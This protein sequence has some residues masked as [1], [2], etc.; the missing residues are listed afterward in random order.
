VIL[1][2]E[3][4]HACQ[5][6][7]KS[8]WNR[9]AEENPYWYVSSY[10]SY[11]ADRNLEEFWATRHTIWADMHLPSYVALR[12]GISPI[13]LEATALDAGRIL[14]FGRCELVT[15]RDDHRR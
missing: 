6:S 12:S 14:Y 9:G 4:S 2:F 10:G 1:C 3:S 7:V 11:G 13:R 15:T 8:F 5:Q